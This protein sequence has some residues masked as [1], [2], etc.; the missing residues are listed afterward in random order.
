MTR[1]PGVRRLDV[2]PAWK[3]A[4]VI[5]RFWGAEDVLNTKGEMLVTVGAA[6]L[7]RKVT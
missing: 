2:D 6:G 3:F 5:V 1:F 7:T 4:P